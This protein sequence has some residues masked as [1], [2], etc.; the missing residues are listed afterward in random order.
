ML[1][2]HFDWPIV[3]AQAW[4]AED[5]HRFW[6]RSRA[7]LVVAGDFNAAP[8]SALVRRVED[9]TRTQVLPGWRPSFFGGVGGRSGL[10]SVPFGLPVDH[11]LVSDGI[12]AAQARTV[13]LPGA[14]HRAV[15]VRLSAPLR[16]GG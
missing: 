5:F 7:P 16:G 8:W 12:G 4:Q 3:G 13:A 10:L 11:V 2:L 1:A 14:D 6:S 9:I 15:V